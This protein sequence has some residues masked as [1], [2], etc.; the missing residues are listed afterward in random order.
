[1]TEKFPLILYYYIPNTTFDKN[2]D[3]P[4]YSGY[5]NLYL[6]I[7]DDNNLSNNIGNLIMSITSYKKENNKYIIYGDKTIHIYDKYNDYGIIHTNN[8]AIINSNQNGLSTDAVFN[9]N[10]IWA[11]LNYEYLNPTYSQKNNIEIIISDSIRKIIIPEPFPYIPKIY[12]FKPG[13]YY[14]DTFSNF[15]TNVKAQEY[16]LWG[17]LFKNI[18][19]FDK[20][21]AKN[22]YFLS[23]IN[24]N[25]NTYY[26]EKFDFKEINFYTINDEMGNTGNIVGIV[27]E[28]NSVI[29]NNGTISQY[30]NIVEEDN[31]KFS[32]I[33]YADGIFNYLNP[34]YSSNYPYKIQLK[35]SSDITTVSFPDIPILLGKIFPDDVLN[36]AV[37]ANYSFLTLDAIINYV[38]VVYKNAKKEILDMAKIWATKI[39]YRDRNFEQNK[40]TELDALYPFFFYDKININN[41]GYIFNRDI[42]AQK[43]TLNAELKYAFDENNIPTGPTNGY[44]VST[45][46][47]VTDVIRLVR[48]LYV[49][50][51]NNDGSFICGI[52][53]YNNNIN[54]PGSCMDGVYQFSVINSQGY[55]DMKYFYI[56]VFKG[57]FHVILINFDSIDYKELLNACDIQPGI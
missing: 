13:F 30:D 11:N 8:S 50:I 37:T 51:R 45:S 23:V 10:I 2:M 1:M 56:Y 25:T 22:G 29:N 41:F 6:S 21:Y 4:A 43:Y 15:N 28:T 46:Y 54:S 48:G 7:D 35:L 47:I 52:T 38:E 42:N 3:I 36:T 24:C 26:P 9:E 55:N 5:Q 19:V 49:N 27:D 32:I 34:Y 18:N 53:C 20:P 40:V 44:I 31:I 17:T 16:L 57:L 33:L 12:N 39:Y 14:E